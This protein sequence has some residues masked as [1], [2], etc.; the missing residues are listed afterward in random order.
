MDVDVLFDDEICFQ[1]LLKRPKNTM[2]FAMELFEQ[3]LKEHQR[4]DSSETE[5]FE[6]YLSE[7]YEKANDYVEGE[8]ETEQQESAGSGNEDGDGRKESRDAD[9][10]HL[11]GSQDSKDQASKIINIE[12]EEERNDTHEIQK[13]A[14]KE[15]DSDESVRERFHESTDELLRAVLELLTKPLMKP[16]SDDTIQLC[17]RLMYNFSPSI[18]LLSSLMLAVF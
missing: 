2:R 18:S 16:D 1:I 7:V 12:K 15:A 10:I 6:R 13:G 9:E 14:H 5:L 3:K 11:T 8:D 17:T 4:D